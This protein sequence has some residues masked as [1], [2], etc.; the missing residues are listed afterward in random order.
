MAGLILTPVHVRT[1]VSIVPS[2]GVEN[3]TQHEI[4]GNEHKVNSQGTQHI[5]EQREKVSK[6][7]TDEQAEQEEGMIWIHFLQTVF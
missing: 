2:G 7:R 5:K 1:V 3:D 4:E 6:I